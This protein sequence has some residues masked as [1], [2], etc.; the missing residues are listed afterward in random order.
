MPDEPLGDRWDSLLERPDRAIERIALEAS[1]FEEDPEP[2]LLQLELASS[3]K[4]SGRPVAV[5]NA[6]G[7]SADGDSEL[8]SAIATAAPGTALSARGLVDA[9]FR[10]MGDA[11]GLS[12]EGEIVLAKRVEA[13]QRAMLESLCR[14]PMVAERIAC[15]GRTRRRASSPG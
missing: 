12:R 14:V 6:V 4:A 7:G 9:Y 5:K 8:G 1:V 3:D 10:Q 15:W 11:G 13:S 2:H